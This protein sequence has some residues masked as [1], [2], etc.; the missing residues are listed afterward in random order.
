[1]NRERADGS[2]DVVDL[3]EL[4]A[5]YGTVLLDC[6]L[7]IELLGTGMS[8]GHHMLASVL[9]PFYRPLGLEGEQAGEN[10][11]L[12]YEMNFLSEAA[13]DV[14][15]NNP[16]IFQ[17]QRLPQGII[18]HFWHLSI[19][20]DGQFSAR[21][22]KR[23]DAGQGFQRCRAVA[24]DLEFIPHHG[25]CLFEGTVDIAVGKRSLPCKV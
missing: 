6:G 18:D 2:S 20:P 19:D 5:Q 12:A 21:R 22:V 3:F 25:I 10:R 17:S 15:D 8:C 13:P 1:M 9:D 7:D 14:R 24:V 16:H 4:Q 11:V 23:G